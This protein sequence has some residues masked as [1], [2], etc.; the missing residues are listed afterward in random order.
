MLAFNARVKLLCKLAD[1]IS[2][3]TGCERGATMTCKPMLPPSANETTMFNP[4]LFAP[5][6]RETFAG[7]GT[8]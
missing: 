6:H 4:P 2:K 3:A 8:S 5:R 7:S 1:S